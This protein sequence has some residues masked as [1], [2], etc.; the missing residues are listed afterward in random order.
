MWKHPGVKFEKLLLE[1]EKWMIA[2]FGG[3]L[4]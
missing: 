3:N 4:I 2:P 1:E